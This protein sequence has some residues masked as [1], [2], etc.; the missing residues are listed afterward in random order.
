MYIYNGIKQETGNA[1]LFLR[2]T[3]A[4]EVLSVPY[5]YVLGTKNKK[6]KEAKDAE[7]KRREKEIFQRE[8]YFEHLRMQHEAW[9]EAKYG[10]SAKNPE[11]PERESSTEVMVGCYA[12]D[13]NG[14]Y[15]GWYMFPFMKDFKANPIILY[16][17]Y[18]VEF[19]VYFSLICAILAIIKGWIFG[20]SA[21]RRKYR[22]DLHYFDLQTVNWRNDKNIN[23]EVII[24]EYQTYRHETKDEWSPK[25]GLYN[26]LEILFIE[27]L[28]KKKL[29]GPMIEIK[30][31][32][33]VEFDYIDEL[34]DRGFIGQWFIRAIRYN[35][36]K[37]IESYNDPNYENIKHYTENEKGS[38]IIFPPGYVHTKTKY[39]PFVNS[40]S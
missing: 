39:A 20:T 3:E 34:L 25:N 18:A 19:I 7:E 29:E 35:P 1:V 24:R 2:L 14:N 30:Y 38:S 9:R 4:Q 17:G 31:L 36:Q 28:T 12:Y 6:T 32:S 8:Q 5:T 26:T 27:K 13:E 33:K 23:L 40:N 22:Q 10:K 16:L 11:K 15:L 21:E 37:L